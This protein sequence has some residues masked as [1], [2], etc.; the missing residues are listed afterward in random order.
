MD[1]AAFYDS[2]K[3]EQRAAFAKRAGTTP[4]YIET[5]LIAPVGRR[6]M[7]RK[8]RIFAFVKAS[9]GKLTL[10]D[11]LAYFYEREPEKKRA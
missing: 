7:P 2:L 9:E 5:H 10:D 1:F 3:T 6:V 11:V 4:L 8:K